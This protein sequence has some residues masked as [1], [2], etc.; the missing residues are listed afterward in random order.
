VVFGVWDTSGGGWIASGCQ[1]DDARG[2]RRNVPSD[3]DRREAEHDALSTLESYIVVG[4][5]F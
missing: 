3:V 2:G 1:S 4:I 5:S